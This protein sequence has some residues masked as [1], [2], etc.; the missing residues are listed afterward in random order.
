MSKLTPPPNSSTGPG[1]WLTGLL[2]LLV[3]CLIGYGMCSQ[4]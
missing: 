4:M 2:L 1:C 3:L